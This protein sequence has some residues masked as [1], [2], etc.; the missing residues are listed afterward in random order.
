MV[1]VDP[2]GTRQDLDVD[3]IGWSPVA[4]W[5]QAVGADAGVFGGGG[6]I[7]DE[8]SLFNLPYHLAR[9]AIWRARRVPWVGI[10]LGA[11]PLRFAA[12]RLLVS[13]VLRSAGAITVRDP[14]SARVLESLLPRPPIVAS[15]LVFTMADGAD[16]TSRGTGDPGPPED[17]TVVSLRG[18]TGRRLLPAGSEGL[19]DTPP[20]FVEAMAA[21]L[22]QVATAT[23]RST[24]F[25]AFDGDNDDAV[26]AAVAARMTTPTER[27]V[28]DVHTVLADVAT[29]RVVV[30]MRY[31]ALVAA[32]LAGRPAVAL[33]Y[34]PKVGRLA[35]RLGA[36][37]ATLGLAPTDIARI[38]DALADVAGHADA[39]LAARAALAQES[40]AHRQVL[41]DHLAGLP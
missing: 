13:R 41:A 1:S 39:V 22:D 18:W 27:R 9:P 38:P 36:G 37:A 40:R 7:Q 6:I 28:P 11:H 16:G 5:R 25:V 23:R 24:R 35:P 26:H 34:T 10:G 33:A 30:A 8:T 12:S 4:V 20:G 19:R 14:E 3:A 32:T 2:D 31:H 17:V 21:A 15:D 29:G